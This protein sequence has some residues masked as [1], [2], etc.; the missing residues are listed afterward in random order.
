MEK[1]TTLHALKRF[2]SDDH[3]VISLDFQTMDTEDFANSANFCAAFAEELIDSLDENTCISEERLKEFEDI[4]G[5]KPARMASLF[6]IISKWCEESEK[7]LVLMIDEVD[8]ASN[9]QVFLDFLSQLRA[10]YLNRSEKATFKSVI[11]AGVYDVRNLKLKIRD[12][13][14]HKYNSPWNIAVNFNVDMNLTVTGI[15]GMLNDYE[16]DHNTG[17]DV[18][19]VS[20][21]IY[22]YTSGYP[23]LVSNICKLIDEDIH[24]W[25]S[26]GIIKAVNNI[27]TMNTPL[28]ESLINK[29]ETYPDMKSSLYNMLVNGQK[30][31]YNPDN[32]ATK[33]LLMFG[34]VKVADNSIV[35]ANRIFETRLYNDMLTSEEIK[36]TPIARAGSFDKPEFIKD[37]ILDI[38][39]IFRRFTEHFKEIYGENTDRFIEED[40]RKCFLVYLRPIINGIGNYYIEAQTRDNRRMDIVVDYLGKRYIIE[41]KIWHGNKYNENGEK[42][43]SDYLDSFNLKKGYLLTFSFNKNKDSGVKTT[44]FEGKTIVEAVV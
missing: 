5:G 1:T 23:V 7:P 6:K 20:K 32:E 37:G 16:K 44:L 10:A 28:F 38:E 17:M 39:L 14:E 15:T 27:L 25:T 29:L 41:L 22:D 36:A 34:F 4:A 8:N 43:L 2:L 42:Q 19:S 40:A 13:N 18:V 35:I 31:S 21:L 30:L 11:L 33:L 9:N 3:T 12:E 26:D 24:E